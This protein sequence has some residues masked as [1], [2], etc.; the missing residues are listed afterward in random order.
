MQVNNKHIIT[1]DEVTEVAKKMREAGEMLGLIHGHVDK[2]GKKVVTYDYYIGNAVESYE[3]QDVTSLPSISGI[4][5]AAAEWPEREINEL[6]DVEFEG[7]DLT[8]RL[9]LP[10]DLLDGKGQI[11]VTPL[12]EL[13][14]KNIID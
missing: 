3:V 8:K 13:R 12:A 1:K 5:D 7:L 6:M 11:L 4:Y 10:N 9:F 14:E 2:E